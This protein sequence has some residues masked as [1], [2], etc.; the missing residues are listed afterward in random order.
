MR[1]SERKDGM[2]VG[3]VFVFMHQDLKTSLTK[4]YLICVCSTSLGGT[5]NPPSF[6]KMHDFAY[7]KT[8]LY[9]TSNLFIVMLFLE[10]FAGKVVFQVPDGVV[11]F[12]QRMLS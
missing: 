7:C 3:S 12:L 2:G 1:V 8:K 5:Y 6:V 10:S 4:S 9:T 11:S